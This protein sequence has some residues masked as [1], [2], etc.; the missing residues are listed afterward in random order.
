MCSPA[1]F[2][3]ERTIFTR[4]FE[5]PTALP[6]QRATGRRGA[7]QR[8]AQLEMSHT[9][10]AEDGV[11]IKVVLRCR[12]MTKA[13]SMKDRAV[14]NCVSDKVVEVN[15]ASMGKQ[16]KKGFTFDGVFDAASTQTEVYDGVVRPV[17]DEVLQG[18]NCTVF[19]YGQTG[20]GK[21]HTMEGDVSP[22]PAGVTKDAA[23][24]IPRAVTQVFEYL[25]SN[26]FEYTVRISVVEL[27]NEELAD[28]I[29]SSDDGSIAGNLRKLR[30]MEDPK[31]GIVLQGVEERAVKDVKDIFNLLET[32]NKQVLSRLCACVHVC[33]CRYIL[34]TYICTSRYMYT[35]THTHTHTH[36]AADRGDAVQQAVVAI[37]PDLHPEDLHEG[38][39]DRG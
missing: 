5:K 10:N 22:G 35:N 24:I 27:Y 9:Y 29:A 31:K 1:L 15:Y 23:G 11:N 19:A 4:S 21:T 2:K 20:T 16:A 37:A 7:V 33:G 36:T 17:V 26:G 34:Y 14:I 13:E 39:D 18:Y 30:L 12:P 32:T 8:E 3:V 28:L 38:T 6:W 25:E